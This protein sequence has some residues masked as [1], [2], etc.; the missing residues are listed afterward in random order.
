MSSSKTVAIR[1]R[2]SIRRNRSQTNPE[3]M[4]ALIIIWMRIQIK[5][6]SKLKVPLTYKTL[7]LRTSMKW[8]QKMRREVSN[9]SRL[10]RRKMELTPT[11][12]TPQNI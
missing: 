10:G 2:R 11:T 3:M 6:L 8:K 4:K 1:N 12:R 9:Q 7:W 5:K